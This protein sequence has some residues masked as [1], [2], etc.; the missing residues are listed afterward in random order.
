M[1]TGTETVQDALR[2]IGAHSEISPAPSESLDV[3]F[4]SLVSMVEM[5]LS[6]GIEL[7]IIPP[8]KIADDLNEPPDARLAIRSS[9]ALL[10]APNYGNGKPTV[11][12]DLAKMQR[13][14]YGKVKR[15][16]RAIEIPGKV[17]S[18]T[19]PV[20]AGNDQGYGYGS[21][22]Q[23]YFQKGDKLEN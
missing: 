13:L 22:R 8:E 17:V 14:Q 16:Y 19:L 20:G 4:R 12:A 6:E 10:L 3:G 18:S 5:W 15:K 2:L 1:S 23:T 21:R 7:G 11:S 9:L